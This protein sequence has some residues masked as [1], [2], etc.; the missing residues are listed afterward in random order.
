MIANI[1][2][3]EGCGS[4]PSHPIQ[5]I[6]SVEKPPF[7]APT[8]TEFPAF[9]YS[10]P[11]PQQ[12]DLMRFIYSSLASSKCSIIE[13]PTG[14]GKSVSLLTSCLYW[15]MDHNKA[16]KAHLIN[17]RDY[18]SK[19]SDRLANETDWIA[20]HSRKRALRLQIESEMEPLEATQ[21]A[22]AEASELIKHAAE[23]MQV[24][25]S[26]KFAAADNDDAT[27]RHSSL[28][29]AFNEWDGSEDESFLP[30]VETDSGKCVSYSVVEVGV[31][32]PHVVQ[33]IYCSR[34]HSQLAQVVEELSKLKGLSDQVT[35][36]TLASR[37][38]LCVNKGVYGLRNQNMI[39][40]ACL[41]LS[42][43]SPGCRFRCRSDVNSLSYYLLGA[44]V[45]AI[46]AASQ[47]RKVSESADIEEIPFR[48]CPYYANKQSLPLAQLILA[49]YQTV[50]VPASREAVG[51][52]LRNTVLIFDEAHN[53]L[54]AVAASFSAAILHTDLLATESLVGAFLAHYRS[55]LSSL[56]ALRLRQLLLVVKGFTNLLEGKKSRAEHQRSEVENQETSSDV[57]YT[58]GDFLFATG[59]DHINLSYLVDYLRRDRCVHKI[60]GFGKWFISQKKKKKNEL[61]NDCPRRIGSGL[62][63]SECMKQLKR[64]TSSRIVD[65]TE[66]VQ[67]KRLKTDDNLQVRVRFSFNFA[68]I[69]SYAQ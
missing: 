17:L 2:L 48:A 21:K 57:V 33:I 43:K 4:P 15:L 45:S 16:I 19:E 60:A 38:I 61:E 55:R 50:V 22:L 58:V 40:E 53:L 8:R 28:Y 52:S 26:S 65:S 62:S 6:E 34:T 29:E 44:R 69:A 3:D 49:P 41:D 14:T 24:S 36:V 23:T 12:V 56:S 46:E 31:E 30:H 51:L 13:S 42:G 25:K 68:Y 66:S 67:P 47:I 59:L 1:P 18:L 7:I 32:K 37:Q 54:E 11:Y 35:M 10:K 9:P 20:A 64:S 5:S 39:R 27:E 63:F